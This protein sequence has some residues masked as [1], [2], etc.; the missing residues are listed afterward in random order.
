MTSRPAQRSS[1]ESAAVS[2]DHARRLRALYRHL[3]KHFGPLGWWPAESAFE[4]IIGAYLTQN[5]AWTSVERSIANL[6]AYSALT[7][8][9]VRKMPVETLLLLIRPSGYMIRKA[10][11]LKAF[12]AWLDAHY[13][14]SLDALASVPMEQARLELLALPGVGPETAD[15]ILLYAL[16]QPA[17]VVDEYLR[18][19]V[20]RHGLLHAKPRHEKIQSLAVAAFHDDAPNSLVRHFNEFHA[21]VVE[22]GKRW[23]RPVPRC[24][25]CPLA[26]DLAHIGGKP[27]GNAPP[28]TKPKPIS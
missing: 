27:V 3:A 4:V 17:M 15:A 16:H 22:V 21:V 14:G 23:C 10:A 26:F 28:A 7:L 25:D 6:R 8:E 20:T 2:A 24:A 19:I 1:R 11:A 18:R 12:V 13:A 9:G 5:T